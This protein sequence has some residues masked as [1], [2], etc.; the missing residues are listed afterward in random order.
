VA[1]KS[2][3]GDLGAPAYAADTIVIA[4]S[5]GMVYSLS[6]PALTQNWSAN[7]GASVT[8]APVYD[9]QS[10]L[11]F[12]GNGNGLITA[13]DASSGAI[14]WTASATK[15]IAGLA[16]G[17]KQVFAGSSDGYVY[18]FDTATGAL[19][20]K[21]TG[22]GSAVTALDV[23]GGGPAFGT[24]NGNM[25][26]V[27]SSG[28]IYYTRFYTASPIMGLAGAG[29]DEFGA[30]QGGELEMMRTNDGGWTWQSG[31]QFGIGPVILDAM[32]FAGSQDGTLY[33]FT[34][35][36]YTPPPQASVQLGAATVFVD[37]TG[38]TAAQAP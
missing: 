35:Q 36:G 1:T 13:Y 30:T 14:K 19:N 23:N 9:G 31:A 20:W 5:T 10:G 8:A 38:C 16:V 26:D 21:I 7:A 27:K 17:G 24:A 11:V 22:D 18:A 32:L 3:G 6:D 34:P 28:K 15:A 25:Y 4:S 37:G 29:T 12:V 2:L 33:A